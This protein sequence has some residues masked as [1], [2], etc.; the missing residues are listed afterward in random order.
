MWIECDDGIK[1]SPNMLVFPFLCYFLFLFVYLR[2]AV[3][4]LE[5]S[6]LV[7][8]LIHNLTPRSWSELNLI[9]LL[10]IY[11]RVFSIK[12]NNSTKSKAHFFKKRI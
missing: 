12:N 10:P 9:S 2:F 7:L 8:S 3:E 1:Q 5:S 11:N 6:L 4:C